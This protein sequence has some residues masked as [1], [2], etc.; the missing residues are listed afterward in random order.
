MIDSLA[1]DRAL[2]RHVLDLLVDVPQEQLPRVAARVVVEE[3]GQAAERVVLGI[4]EVHGDAAHGAA[5]SREDRG[6]LVQPVFPERDRVNQL[7]HERGVDPMHRTA[8]S[9]RHHERIAAGII[10]KIAAQFFRKDEHQLL[11]LLV[12]FAHG[13]TAGQH[14]LDRRQQQRLLSFRVA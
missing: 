13:Q 4:G 7:H 8:E 2:E 6:V 9:Q 5:R 14:F 11:V 1:L 3:H 12:V 10:G